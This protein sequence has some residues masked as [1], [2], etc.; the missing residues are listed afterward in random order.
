MPHTKRKGRVRGALSGLPDTDPLQRRIEGFFPDGTPQ[1]P[2]GLVAEGTVEE[3]TQSPLTLEV[4]LSPGEPMKPAHPAQP[5]ASP[6]TT[7]TKSDDHLARGDLVRLV[8]EHREE[9]GGTPWKGDGWLVRSPDSHGEESQLRPVEMTTLGIKLLGAFGDVRGDQSDPSSV[10][11]QLGQPEQ[12]S[13]ETV[14]SALKAIEAMLKTLTGFSSVAQNGASSR[15]ES[16]EAAEDH[17]AVPTAEDREGEVHFVTTAPTLNLLNHEPLLAEFLHETLRKKDYLK[18]PPFIILRSGPE[19][20]AEPTQPSAAP[21]SMQ[22]PVSNLARQANMPVFSDFI[23]APRMSSTSPMTSKVPMPPVAILGEKTGTADRK[24]P[25]ERVKMALTADVLTTY[26]TAAFSGFSTASAHLGLDSTEA[27]AISRAGPMDAGQVTAAAAA[28]SKA[29]AAVTSLNQAITLPTQRSS[30][31]RRGDPTVDVSMTTSSASPSGDEE[32]ATTTTTSTITTTTITTMDTAG[33]CSINFTGPE[34]YITSPEQSDWRHL[35]GLDCTYSLSVYAGYG[36]EVKVQNISLAEGETITVESLGGPEPLILA[37][38]S[39]LMK[40]QVIRSPSNQ[41][42][43]HFQSLNLGHPGTFHFRYQAYLLSCRF[44]RRP[45]YGDVSVTS[46]H[47]G[48]DAYFYCSTGY[49][50][51][52]PHTVTCLNATRPFWS[53]KE[54]KCIAA[55]GGV[56][57][58]ATI[59]RIISP[60]FPGNYSHNLT[61][62]WLLEAPEAQRLHLHFEK[63]SLA[64]DDDRLII[65]NGENIDAAPVYDSYEVEYLPIEGLVSGTQHFFIE[66]TTDS[67]GASIGVALRYEA[68]AQGH[69]YEPFIKYGN[70]TTSDSSY[71][72][73]TVVEFT[74]DPGYTLEQGSIIIECVDYAD[75]QWNET[76]PACRAV[77]SG[78]ITDSAGVVLSPN[79]PEAYGK[80]QDCIWGIHVDEDKRILLD[81]QVLTM[82]RN[83]I[84]TFYDGDDLSARILGQYMGT[85]R[86]FKL[87]TSTADVT[88]QF[89]TDPGSSVFGYRQGFV[90]HF[91]EVPRN[92]TCP[93]LPEI[94][95][96]WKTSSQSELTHGTVVTYQCYPGYDITGAELLMCQWDLTWSGDLPT[97]ERVTS[98]S[99]PGDV[100]H[101]RRLLTSSKFPVGSTVR[102]LCDK[103]YTLTGSSLL[104]CHGRQTGTPKWSDRLPKCVPDIY[105]ACHNPGVPEKALQSPERPLYQAGDVLQF[106]CATGYLLVGDAS[107]IC[108]PGHPSQWNSSPPVCKAPSDDFYSDHSLAA[109]AKPVSSQIHPEGRNLLI[110]IFVPVA[111]VAVVIGGVYFYFAKLQGKTSLRIPLPG[112]HPY[113]HITVESSFDNPTFE[114]GEMREYEVSI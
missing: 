44:P 19:A 42:I 55:C 91:F 85:Q 18:E 46:L 74:C 36:V 50:L 111:I 105:E 56:I 30:P 38:E 68:F 93:E 41:V 79:W 33:P 62:H 72:V 14:W 99:D 52:G 66:L 10:S 3:P 21:Q 17:T 113:S 57:R 94:P 112:S 51:Q 97:C 107:I 114:T 15:T 65:R 39:F 84:L 90:V 31:S 87:Y 110:S 54:P 6:R 59:G 63:V 104:T 48:G 58:N 43:I 53:S 45:A 78:E 9:Q 5:V 86:R 4:T 81:I 106:S 75:P 29:P 11:I 23:T 7:E 49:Q 95:N 109:A 26:P 22:A 101:S 102:F 71:S 16:S 89:Q 103:G 27:A 1:T 47:P 92:D 70:L 67:S 76:E 98:C 83:D 60:G 69:C 73:G 80:G 24:R 61:C 40:G 25:R 82:G 77:C 108:I 34:G 88:I 13:L 2:V 32:E 64:E 12:I 8:P 100:A 96:G 35:S 20:G 37:N 28:I